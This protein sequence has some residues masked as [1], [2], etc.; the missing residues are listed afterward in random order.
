MAVAVVTA[1]NS[2]QIASILVSMVEPSDSRS[3]WSSDSLQSCDDE[4]M[5]DVT[6]IV[7]RDRKLK[8][9]NPTPY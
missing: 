8:I 3:T 1:G 5:L 7:S 2:R 9:E 4:S 6:H